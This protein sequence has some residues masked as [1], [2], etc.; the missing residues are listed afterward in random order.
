MK[1]RRDAD[2]VLLVTEPTPFGMND[3]I[4]AVET[5]KE[6]KKKFA[7]IVNRYGI[8]DD[9]VI[10]YCEKENIDIIARIPDSR[11]I[12]SLYSMGK[13]IYRR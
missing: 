7:V 1:Q 9:K 13:L 8:G 11:E 3:L 4:L 5:M 10:K 12:A 6:L 2:L